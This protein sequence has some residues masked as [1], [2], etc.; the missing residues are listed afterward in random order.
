MGQEKILFPRKVLEGAHI[1]ENKQRFINLNKG[2]GVSAVY[3]KGKWAWLR[4]GR[5]EV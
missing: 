1:R 5:Q 4:M 2:I 3:G